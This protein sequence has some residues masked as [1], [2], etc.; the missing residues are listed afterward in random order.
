M[1]VGRGEGLKKLWVALFF[2]EVKAYGGKIGARL[3]RTQIQG[4]F[5]AAGSR[6]VANPLLRGSRDRRT[7]VWRSGAD[8]TRPL[9]T[10]PQAS[11]PPNPEAASNRSRVI[12]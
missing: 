10:K 5:P 4:S 9:G 1:N 7:I 6:G 11:A 8:V 2:G 3:R 12:L